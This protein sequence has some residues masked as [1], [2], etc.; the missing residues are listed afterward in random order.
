[1]S[2]PF[3]ASVMDGVK[4]FPFFL[5][6][7]FATDFSPAGFSDSCVCVCVVCEPVAGFPVSFS[8]CEKT[9]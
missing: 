5:I 7:R 9:G 6:I 1:V 8:A 2:F 4:P 3:N